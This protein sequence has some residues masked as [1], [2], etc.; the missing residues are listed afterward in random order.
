MNC[1]VEFL[2]TWPSIFRRKWSPV[3]QIMDRQPAWKYKN[4]LFSEIRGSVSLQ[5]NKIYFHLSWLTALPIAQFFS[6]SRLESMETCTMGISVNSSPNI[7]RKGMKT[8]WSNPGPEKPRPSSPRGSWTD[9][10]LAS[11]PA[12]EHTFSVISY[13]TLNS[14]S[15][16]FIKL[17]YAPSK[18]TI[19]TWFKF[20]LIQFR[21]KSIVIH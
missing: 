17:H 2:V 12:F 14:N 18:V 9:V 10:N 7:I 20:Q 3:A 19:S 8:P 11:C 6:G 15:D 4:T 16:L 1:F 5:R 21:R 13:T